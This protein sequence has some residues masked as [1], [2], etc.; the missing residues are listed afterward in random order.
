MSWLLDDGPF[1]HLAQQ[2][3]LS[4]NWPADTIHVVYSVADDAPKDQSGRRQQ[5][6]AMGGATPAVRVHRP[7]NTSPAAQYLLTH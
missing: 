5:L 4:W 1:G 6:L 2:F 3:D 7:L